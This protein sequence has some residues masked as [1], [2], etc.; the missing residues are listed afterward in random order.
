M[1]ASVP[2]H[3]LRFAF[4]RLLGN[5]G[6]VRVL[7]VLCRAA[8]PLGVSPLAEAAGLTPQ[9]TRM[10]LATLVAHRLVR[11]FCAGRARLYA[12][13]AGHP[14]AAALA[15]LFRQEQVRW[16]RLMLA[17]R[18]L[19]SRHRVVRAAWCRGRPAS[20]SDESPDALDIVVV[21]A[22]L[23]LD[24]S[25][26]A[27]A[28]RAVPPDRATLAAIESAL[29]ELDARHFTRS[30]LAAF[31]IDRLA[32]LAAD[33]RWW[34]DLIADAQVLKGGDPALLPTRARPALQSSLFAPT[35]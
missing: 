24:G 26:A 1:L 16:E 35:G 22:S 34:N 9:G 5:A 23:P 33:R 30:R 29:A 8:D 19:M 13:D 7:R 11:A 25:T 10:V 15:D 20:E 18:G 31:P 28:R 4:T 32:V 3:S 14:L 17:L 27:P 12:I 2:Q 21:T 6:Q